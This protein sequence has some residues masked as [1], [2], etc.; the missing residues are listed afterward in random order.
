LV[1]FGSGDLVEISLRG[2]ER[3]DLVD[4]NLRCGIERGELVEF[5]SRGGIGFGE[6]AEA[7]S[8]GIEFGDLVNSRGDIECKDRVALM[9]SQLEEEQSAVKMS[10]PGEEQG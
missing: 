1:E 5:S 3:G 9:T 10:Q 8:R 6:L 7:G 4:V 2:I